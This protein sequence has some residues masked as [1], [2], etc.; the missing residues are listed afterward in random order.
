MFEQT[1]NS[2]Y[3]LKP[4]VMWDKGHPHFFRFNAYNKSFDGIPIK[5]LTIQVT[6]DFIHDKA[7]AYYAI[8]A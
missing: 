8:Q 4:S 2:G 5:E 3:V 7:T 6:C 1:G